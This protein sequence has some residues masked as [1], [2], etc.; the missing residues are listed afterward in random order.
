MQRTWWTRAAFPRGLPFPRARLVSSL[1]FRDTGGTAP[2]LCG[3]GGPRRAHLGDVPL[4]PPWCAR[5]LLAGEDERE[6][7][8]AAPTGRPALSIH[9]GKAAQ[10][11]GEAAIPV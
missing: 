3:H 5:A 7:G 1:T 10:M 9:S 11:Q 6:A 4:V 2:G 8:L